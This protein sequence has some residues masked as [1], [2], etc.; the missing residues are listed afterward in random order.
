V[1]GKDCPISCNDSRTA[2]TAARGSS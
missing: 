2:V 1:N